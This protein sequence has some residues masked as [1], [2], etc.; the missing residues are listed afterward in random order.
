MLL[1]LILIS[2][3]SNNV[4]VNCFRQLCLDNVNERLSTQRRLLSL[5]LS[6]ISVCVARS[7]SYLVI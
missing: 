5:I 7:S 1:L 4:V 3:M 2:C 6:V